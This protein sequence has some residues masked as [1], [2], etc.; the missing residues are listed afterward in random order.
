MNWQSFSSKNEERTIIGTSSAERLWLH[1]MVERQSQS[2]RVQKD[3]TGR[4]V[5][6][7]IIMGDV[8]GSVDFDVASDLVCYMYAQ[9]KTKD[10]DEARYNRLMQVSGKVDQ[11][12][13]D[14]VINRIPK[15]TT[16]HVSST[17]DA[18]NDIFGA[19]QK[20]CNAGEGKPSVTECTNALNLKCK[21][22]EPCE[23]EISFDQPDIIASAEFEVKLNELKNEK[24]NLVF[25]NEELLQEI[26]HINYLCEED[27]LKFGHQLNEMKLQIKNIHIEY[28]EEAHKQSEHFRRLYKELETASRDYI[29]LKRNS[30][31]EIEQLQDELEAIKNQKKTDEERINERYESKMQKIRQDQ[32]IQLSKMK[33][34]HKLFQE[35]DSLKIVLDLKNEEIHSLRK[36]NMELQKELENLP[37]TRKK[38][39]KLTAK[40]EDL[41]ELLNIKSDMER[42]LTVEHESLKHTVETENKVNKRLSMEIEELQW[43]LKLSDTTVSD[44]VPNSSPQSYG[45]SAKRSSSVSFF[46]SSPKSPE[47]SNI[48]PIPELFVSYPSGDKALDGT[49]ELTEVSSS[50]STHCE[51]IS[52]NSASNDSNLANLHD[53]GSCDSELV[54]SNNLEADIIITTSHCQPV[55]ENKCEVAQDESSLH[56]IEDGPLLLTETM[57]ETDCISS[58]N[59]GETEQLEIPCLNGEQKHAIDSPDSSTDDSK[60]FSEPTVKSVVSVEPVK[61]LNKEQEQ[62]DNSVTS[63]NLQLSVTHSCNKNIQC[64]SLSFSHVYPSSKCDTYA[65]NKPDYSSNLCPDDSSDFVATQAYDTKSSLN[66]DIQPNHCST[67]KL[68]KSSMVLGNVSSDNGSTEISNEDQNLLLSVSQHLMLQN[69]TSQQSEGLYFIHYVVDN[70]L[71]L[72]TKIV[73]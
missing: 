29:D 24:E 19:I 57:T 71:C 70:L 28:G 18:I 31:K 7:F 44:C 69:Q 54:F 30:E 62:S 5:N 73:L 51:F 1:L 25:K 42:S 49:K 13:I 37:S 22:S 33:D 27:R 9:S 3:K 50:A 11:L 21:K 55:L 53:L 48:E 66:F 2:P 38:V 47:K 6:L 43:K 39:V 65:K 63:K 64:Q 26:E 59:D 34:S 52:E 61:K 56:E 14:Y 40:I 36:Q 10:V 32:E 67:P 15:S 60:T 23:L 16:H 45:R 41:Q 35:I 4:F 72:I 8:H 12:S 46:E 17:Y 20:V 58:N 68:N